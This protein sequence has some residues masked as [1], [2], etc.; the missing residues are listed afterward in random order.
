LMVAEQI[1]YLIERILPDVSEGLRSEIIKAIKRHL[2]T[3]ADA[4]RVAAAT[5]K[6]TAS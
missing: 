5:G 2:A 3:E 1:A 4:A 6:P